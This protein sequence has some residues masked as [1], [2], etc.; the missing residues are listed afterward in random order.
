MRKQLEHE[1]AERK[2]FEVTRVSV[3]T[4]LVW[5]TQFE[6]DIGVAITRDKALADGKK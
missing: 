4:F 5:K 2:K 1:E 6:L 3:E